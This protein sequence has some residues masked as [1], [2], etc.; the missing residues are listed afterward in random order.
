[1]HTGDVV[2][3]GARDQEDDFF[4]FSDEARVD[5]CVSCHV[6]PSFVILSV[7]DDELFQRSLRQSLTRFRYRDAEVVFLSANSAGQAA[8][9]LSERSDVALV[10]LDVVMETD[11]AGLRLVRTIREVMGNAEIRIILLTGQPGMAPMQMSLEQFDI[12]DYWLKTDLSNARLHSILVSNLRTWEQIRALNRARRGLQ[13]IV[14]ASNSLARATGF[15]DFACRMILQL[16]TLFGV[17]ADGIVCVRGDSGEPGVARIIGSAGRFQEAVGQPLEALEDDGIRGLLH[18]ALSS[19][20]SLACDD[21]QVIFLA[22]T[23]LEHDHAAAYLAT[24]R[25]LDDTERE[26]LGVFTSNIN[27]GL[28]NVALASRLDH[29]AYQDQLLNIP[30]GNALRRALEAAL[31]LPVPRNR[32][33]L[34]LEL[35]QYAQSCVALGVEQ[36]N[37]MLKNVAARL[38]D[39]FPAPCML[40]RLY[41][42][43]FA[44]LG[45]A[46]AIRAELLSGVEMGAAVDDAPFIGVDSARLDLDQV[47]GSAQNALAT[48]L[49]L[50]KRATLLGGERT[51]SYEPDLDEEVQRRFSRSRDLYR[52]LQRDEI[53]VVFQPQVD[54]STGQ[55]VGAEVLARW[56]QPDGTVIPPG[57]FIPLAEANGL[58]VPL[59]QRILRK[60]CEAQARLM[61]EGFDLVLAVNVSPRQLDREVFAAE[62]ATSCSEFG[63]APPT[64]EL[65]IT[66]SIAVQEQKFAR[67][68]LDQLTASGF[69]LA[70]D[71]FGTG[72]SSLTLLRSLRPTKLKIDR[73]FVARLDDAEEDNSITEM[74]VRLGARMNMVVLAE[75][76]ET[77]AQAQWLR[78][79]GCGLAQGYLFGRPDSLGALLKRLAA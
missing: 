10:L 14:E 31:D 64:I 68:I 35:D 27:T 1:M 62:V 9:V 59:G 77:E 76:V 7:D 26:L 55:I 39:L 37:L 67:G 58:I 71:D 20:Q 36:G 47:H 54:L 46:D 49:L 53:S 6:K 52:A 56:T 4:E 11:D 34:L 57:Q 19:R 29:L 40:A 18:E 50:L 8:K 72:Y 43:T 41:E 23:E 15:Q 13:G 78:Q 30:N 74:M 12:S 38:A 69:P 48:G 21:S 17:Q 73:S 60:A 66:E 32:V 75:G 22:G 70:I 42:D 24:G 65:E 5:P 25:P 79:N 2:R 16:A 33:L 28:V 51:L 61:A 3:T 44:V 45:P 63:V